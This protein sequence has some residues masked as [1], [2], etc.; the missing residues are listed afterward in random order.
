M[1]KVVPA[2]TSPGFMILIDAAKI[3]S[4][5]RRAL[6]LGLCVAD[7]FGEHVAQLSLGL[8]RLA[9]GFL[10]SGHEVHMGMPEGEL[11]PYGRLALAPKLRNT[12]GSGGWI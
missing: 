7:S 2:A 6:S 12:H 9:R 1:A 8:R 4:G 10:P 3:F 5:F 11:N